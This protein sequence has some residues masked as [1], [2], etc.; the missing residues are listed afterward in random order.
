M[1]QLVEQRIRNAWVTSSS[2]VIVS[3]LK[4]APKGGFHIAVIAQLVEQRLP[5]PQVTSSS[6]AYRS[7]L[8]VRISHSRPRSE[9]FGTPHQASQVE[10]RLP[11][12]FNF[13]PII[14]HPRCPNTKKRYPKAFRR[15]TPEKFHSSFYCCKITLYF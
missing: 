5:K 8:A 6:L 11:L 4:R 1:A 14:S 2:L 9:L 3:K 15:V 7:F 12:K 10:P 13:S